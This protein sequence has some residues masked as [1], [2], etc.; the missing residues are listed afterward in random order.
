MVVR[1]QYI[2]DRVES[3]G[4]LTAVVSR[5][6]AHQRRHRGAVDRFGEMPRLYRHTP[7]TLKER[8]VDAVAEHAGKMAGGSGFAFPLFEIALELSAKI[9]GGGAGPSPQGE[10][11]LGTVYRA[12]SGMRRL[13]VVTLQEILHPQFP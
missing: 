12:I 7:G 10:K 11:L 3:D 6:R 4:S 13:A 5:I 2:A 1:G 9:P 8:R